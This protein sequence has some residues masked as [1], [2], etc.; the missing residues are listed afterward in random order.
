MGKDG[1]FREDP[2]E[3]LKAEWEKHPIYLADMGGLFGAPPRLKCRYCAKADYELFYGH[4]R[5]CADKKDIPKKRATSQEFHDAS[6]KGSGVVIKGIPEEWGKKKQ[7]Y[8]WWQFWHWF[9]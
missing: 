5:E 3:P 1:P 8:P 2:K 9:W 4:C 7:T 6:E